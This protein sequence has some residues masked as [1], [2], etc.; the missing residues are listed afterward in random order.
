MIN[1]PVSINGKPGYH[2]Q[3][4]TGADLVLNEDVLKTLKIKTR[5]YGQ[6]GG[7][8]GRDVDTGRSEALDLSMGNLQLKQWHART[9]DMGRLNATEDDAEHS[10]G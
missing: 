10:L 4:D 2:I 6:S 1:I 5:P 7:M 3:L 9:I 8:G